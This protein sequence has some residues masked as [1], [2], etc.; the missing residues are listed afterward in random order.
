ME[1][2]SFV[3]ILTLSALAARLPGDLPGG[4]DHFAAFL[5]L[6]AV[7][8]RGIFPLTPLGTVA[9]TVSTGSSGGLGDHARSL[10]EAVPCFRF[11][12]HFPARDHRTAV[13]AAV[14]RTGAGMLP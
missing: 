13:P 6:A 3:L 10:E 12:T 7:T 2:A 14:G 1:A 11:C 5:Y 4:T 8:I 9:A